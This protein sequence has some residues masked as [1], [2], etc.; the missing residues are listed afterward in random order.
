MHDGLDI[1]RVVD[2]DD[3]PG[4]ML[5]GTSFHQPGNHLERL[6]EIDMRHGHGSIIPKNEMLIFFDITIQEQAWPFRF[7]R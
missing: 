2:Q 7:H 4:S 5:I 6:E 3:F 1:D